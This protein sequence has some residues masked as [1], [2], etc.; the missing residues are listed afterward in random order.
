DQIAAKT[1]GVETTAKLP[2]QYCKRPGCKGQLFI[3]ERSDG[4]KTVRCAADAHHAVQ[5]DTWT[6]MLKSFGAQKRRGPRLSR[7][8]I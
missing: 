5:W 3:A 6:N 1:Y 2:D 4:V 8:L 7:K